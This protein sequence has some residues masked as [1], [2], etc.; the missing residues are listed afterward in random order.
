MECQICVENLGDRAYSLPCGHIYCRACISGFQQRNT[1]VEYFECPCC[2]SSV[3]FSKHL[4]AF[5]DY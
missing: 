4:R 3:W 5:D 1:R 2:R